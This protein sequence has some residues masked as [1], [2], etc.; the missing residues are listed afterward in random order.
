MNRC[1]QTCVFPRVPGRPGGWPR[2]PGHGGV[3][4]RRDAAPRPGLPRQAVA[5]PVDDH[6]LRAGDGRGGL[7]HHAGPVMVPP[8]SRSSGRPSRPGTHRRCGRCRTRGRRAGRWCRPPCPTTSSA[9]NLSGQLIICAPPP[10][11]SST[12]GARESP[13]RSQATSMP[14]GPPREPFLRPVPYHL[15]GT[16]NAKKLPRRTRLPRKVDQPIIPPGPPGK[17]D[18]GSGI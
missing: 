1:R 16:G 12:G 18:A 9:Q 4:S 2:R 15:P 6:Q 3:A 13:K 5:H 14:D 8:R 11:I 10:I 17:R 7:A